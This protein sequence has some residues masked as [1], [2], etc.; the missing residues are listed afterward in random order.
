MLGTLSVRRQLRK[1]LPH[2]IRYVTPH[3]FFQF[4]TQEKPF[5]PQRHPAETP[6]SPE[7]YKARMIV[8]A[9]EGCSDM[10]SL[11]HQLCEYISIRAPDDTPSYLERMASCLEQRASAERDQINLDVVI[12]CLLG[13]PE[14]QA[15]KAEGSWSSLL[16]P[17]GVPSQP[18]AVT[19]TGD[20]TIRHH[21]ERRQDVSIH[22]QY[23]EH[24]RALERLSDDGGPQEYTDY[25]NP[26]GTHT[27]KWDH[28][29][30]QLP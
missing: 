5:D 1:L 2:H 24:E 23:I 12:A 3:S 28:S 26:A 7:L 30:C 13:I 9:G 29:K 16:G 4:W 10:K 20:G 8:V 11:R 27:T 22:Q 6:M 14:S 15:H 17:G 18:S 21:Q 19:T 25:W